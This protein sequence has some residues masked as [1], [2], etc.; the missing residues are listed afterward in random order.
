MARL[1][2]AV[3]PFY[4]RVTVTRVSQNRQKRLCL[5]IASD[6]LRA[7]LQMRRSFFSN[8]SLILLALGTT[9]VAAGI[10]VQA[11]FVFLTNFAQMLFLPGTRVRPPIHRYGFGK[12]AGGVRA[13]EFLLVLLHCLP[14]S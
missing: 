1:G 11:G 5:G 8:Q 12:S 10:C 14:S 6:V 7:T 13:K 4:Y 9:S 2:V 3:K